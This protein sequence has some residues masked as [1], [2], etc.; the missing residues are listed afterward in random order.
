MEPQRPKAI[1]EAEIDSEEERERAKCGR[2]KEGAE[3]VK[4][5][6]AG[7]EVECASEPAQHECPL[8][9]RGGGGEFT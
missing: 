2:L 9:R 6:D 7:T 5:I 8:W 1:K 3:F 4:P